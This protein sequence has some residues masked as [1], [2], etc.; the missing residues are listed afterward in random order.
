MAIDPDNGITYISYYDTTYKDLRM[1]KYV[2]SGGNCGPIGNW[3]C[4]KV[5]ID[6]DVGQYSSLA[7]DMTGQPHFSYYDSEDNDLIYISDTYSDWSGSQRM[8]ILRWAR[9]GARL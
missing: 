8:S 2:G 1:A 7:L 3:W 6:G 4:K 5:D 9:C